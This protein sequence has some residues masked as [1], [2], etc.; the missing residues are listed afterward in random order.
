EVVDIHRSRP[1]Q[2]EEFDMKNGRIV[3]KGIALKD[4]ITFAYNGEDDW[5]RGEKW[6][7]T[8]RFDIA[9]KTAPTESEDTLR[10]MLQAMLADR[11]KLKVHKEPQPVTVYALPVVKSKLKDAAPATRS[12]CRQSAAD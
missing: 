8:E 12:T 4:L 6:L 11:F 9:A 3:A 5:V 10:V 2:Q 1:D 7:E